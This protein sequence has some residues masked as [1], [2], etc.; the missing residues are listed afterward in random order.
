MQSTIA[1]FRH[2]YKH[3]PPLFPEEEKERM[4]HALEHLEKDQTVTLKEIE[5]TM[6]GFGHIAWPWNQAYR[7]FLAVAEGEVGEHFLLPKL[8]PGA[9]NRYLEFKAY[10]GTLRDMHSGHPASYFSEDE[11]IE[12]S[13]ALVDMQIDLRNF[14]DR[15]VLGVERTKYLERV[16]SFSGVLQSIQGKLEE[17]NILAEKELDHPNL[18]DEIRMRVRSFEEGLCLLGPE[19]KYDAVHESIEFFHGRKQ[20][21]NRMRGVHTPITVDFY[22]EET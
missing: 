6:I 8:T 15:K 14:A 12:I 4:H 19:L 1:L 2:L 20:D 5:D 9:Q 10:G 13:T 3:L 11:R 21:L 22:S 17:M 16:A 7:E 18:A